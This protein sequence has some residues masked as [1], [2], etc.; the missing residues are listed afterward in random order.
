VGARGG[1]GSGISCCGSSSRVRGVY[2]KVAVS[3]ANRTSDPDNYT[4]EETF[5]DHLQRNPRLQPYEFWSLMADS[6]VIVQHIASV[7]IF[8]CC[9]VGIY[10]TWISPVSVVSWGSLSTV[11]G[12]VFWDYWVG[13]EEA[14]KAKAQALA[15][16][17]PVEDA[18]SASSTSSLK[19]T[20]GLGLLLPNTS[21]TPRPGHSHSG[22]ATSNV[23]ASLATGTPSPGASSGAPPYGD[24]E[25]SLSPR[26]KQ[27]LATAKSA[28][29]IYCALLGLSPVLKSLT[30]TTTSDSIWAMSTWLMC[31]NVFFF[32][33]GGGTGAQY[34]LAT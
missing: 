3:H 19:D 31:M 6:T 27:R 17:A 2:S 16:A 5:L 10:Y 8:I 29:L 21:S 7:I 13:K 26:N 20:Q 23:S 22:S 14:V 30:E 11:I 12:W 34:I 24:S 28:I 4:D 25:S 9:F 1:R 15:D 33:Y 32:D 18:S